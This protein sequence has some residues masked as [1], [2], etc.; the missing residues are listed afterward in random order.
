MKK[1]IVLLLTLL[2]IPSFA[3]SASYLSQLKSSIRKERVDAAKRIYRA[4]K[5]Q[6]A[7]TYRYLNKRILVEFNSQ[8]GN[9]H[10]ADEIAWWTKA[11]ATSGNETYRATFERIYQE[12]D[13]RNLKRHAKDSLA[14]LSMYANKQKIKSTGGGSSL[15]GLPAKA[16]EYVLSIQSGDPRLQVDG[17]KRIIKAGY[18]DERIY[19]AV[20]KVLLAEFNNSGGD[21]H[22]MDAMAWLCKCLGSSGNA[23]YRPTLEKVA[24]E[25]P[26]KVAGYAKKSLKMIY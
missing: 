9:R 24:A 23:K 14:K 22:K 18:S 7:A 11:L 19:N 20:E 21:R 5:P 2:L 8:P 17:A 16:R 3:L 13:N 1:I 12:A 6:G 15:K 26:R 25:G 4:G 10:H